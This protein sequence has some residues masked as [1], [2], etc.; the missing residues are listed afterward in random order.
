[1]AARRL[2]GEAVIEGV[3]VVDGLPVHRNDEIAGAQPGAGCGT[4]G[5]HA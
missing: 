5:R 2:G 4:L 1:M 3:G